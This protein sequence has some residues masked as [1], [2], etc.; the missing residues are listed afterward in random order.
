M[1]IFGQRIVK[2]GTKYEKRGEDEIGSNKFLHSLYIS[3]GIISKYVE[4][5]KFPKILS[6]LHITPSLP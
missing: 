4:L 3:G 6:T 5:F 1:I 2:G